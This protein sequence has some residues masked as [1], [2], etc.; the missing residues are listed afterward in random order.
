MIWPADKEPDAWDCFF[1]TLIEKGITIGA[2]KSWFK[3]AL[4]KETRLGSTKLYLL[5]NNLCVWDVFSI[6]LIA[7]PPSEH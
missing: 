5:L 1:C 7:P 6:F 3:T 4:Q 2:D